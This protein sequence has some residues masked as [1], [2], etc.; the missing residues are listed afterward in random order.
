MPINPFQFQKVI[1]MHDQID[2][3]Y[4]EFNWDLNNSIFS[5]MFLLNSY[6]TEKEYNK[7]FFDNP[8]YDYDYFKDFF[9]MYCAMSV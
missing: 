6:R 7:K 3:V 5:I 8:H 9:S 4:N 2:N 1:K